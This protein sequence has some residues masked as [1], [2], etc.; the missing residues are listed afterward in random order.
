MNEAGDMPAERWWH[1]RED[2][3]R[4][5][6]A[7]RVRWGLGLIVV[8]AMCFVLGVGGSGDGADAMV[9]LGRLLALVGLGF[10]AVGL[11]RN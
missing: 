4:P 1:K 7:E 9:D 5:S 3:G 6:G 11:F 8:A 10:V 2:K